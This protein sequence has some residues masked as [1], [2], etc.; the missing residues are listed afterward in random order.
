MT[1]QEMSE[2]LEQIILEHNTD[3]LEMPFFIDGE[4]LLLFS[5]NTNNY[6][7]QDKLIQRKYDPFLSVNRRPL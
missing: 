1:D 5:S 7:R 6:P 4:Q 3:Q 2:V